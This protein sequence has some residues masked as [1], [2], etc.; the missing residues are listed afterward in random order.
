V[1][2][3]QPHIFFDDQISHLSNTSTII[4]SVHIPFGIANSKLEEKEKIVTPSEIVLK[5]AEP[6]ACPVSAVSAAAVLDSGGENE[7]SAIAAP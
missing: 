3:S 2:G 4:P 1:E 6:R 5:A 7:S